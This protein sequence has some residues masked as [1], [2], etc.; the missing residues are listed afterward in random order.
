MNSCV[1]FYRELDVVVL[2][3]K[4]Q[5][6]VWILHE[7]FFREKSKTPTLIGYGCIL[8]VSI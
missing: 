1:S 2:I 6:R 4:N 8:N 5:R 3:F 7:L